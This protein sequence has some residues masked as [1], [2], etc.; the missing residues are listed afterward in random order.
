MEKRNFT[1]IEY[2]ERYGYSRSLA[3]LDIKKG[4]LRVMKVGGR[5]LIPIEYAEGLQAKRMQATTNEGDES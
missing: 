3:Y 1:V 2:C 5:T 4:D